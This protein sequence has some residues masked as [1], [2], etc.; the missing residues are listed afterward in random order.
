MATLKVSELKPRGIYREPISG[1]K[2]RFIYAYG[3]GDGL[4]GTVQYYAAAVGKYLLLTVHDDDL[5]ELPKP[6][7]M[8]GIQD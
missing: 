3:H 8:D 1:Q 5:E 6:N 7:W 2:V 4:R